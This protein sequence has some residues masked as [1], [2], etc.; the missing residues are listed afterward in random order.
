MRY[1]QWYQL[2]VFITNKYNQRMRRLSCK[3]FN[4]FY[5]PELTK[6]DLDYGKYHAPVQQFINKWHSDLRAFERNQVLPFDLDESKNHKYYPPHPQY[7]VLTDKLREYGLYRDEHRD[8]NDMMREVN[9]RKG[10]V[11]RERRGPISKKA[12]AKKK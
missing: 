6:T 1:T 4:D 5:V 10:K 3:I 7:R 9:I 12:D 8:F 2:P 11:F